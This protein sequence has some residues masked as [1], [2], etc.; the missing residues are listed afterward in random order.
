MSQQSKWIPHGR[1]FAICYALGFLVC[2][3][4]QA[5]V[6]REH[7][8][9]IYSNLLFAPLFEFREWLGQFV[10]SRANLA[11]QIVSSALVAVFFPAAL[12]LLRSDKR[13]V[14]V[15]SVILLAILTIMT[16]WWGRLPNI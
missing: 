12:A 2:F 9:V 8:P 1:A 4:S 11:V 6:S 14:R 13:A 7:G 5:I 15:L 3:L 16:L 10:Q